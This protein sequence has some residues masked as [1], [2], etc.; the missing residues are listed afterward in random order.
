MLKGLNFGQNQ[1]NRLSHYCLEDLSNLERLSAH[2][3]AIEILKDGVFDG[4]KLKALD[5]SMNSISAIDS[6][7]PAT[8]PKSKSVTNTQLCRLATL[9]ELN[10]N[11]NRLARLPNN[12]FTNLTNLVR[13]TLTDNVIETLQNGVFDLSLIHI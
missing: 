1:L 6:P 8:S 4:L 13:F 10:L 3:N 2:D 9:T 12:C 7:V 5:L 11:K